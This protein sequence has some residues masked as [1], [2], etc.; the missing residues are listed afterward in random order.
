MTKL[1]GVHMPEWVGDD[2]VEKGYV[3]IGW[4]KVGNIFDMPADREAYKPAI[5]AAYPWKKLGQ[6]RSMRARFIDLP[7]RFRQ[8]I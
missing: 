7:T 3:C 4:N 1:W 5:A 6:F 2:P 8:A